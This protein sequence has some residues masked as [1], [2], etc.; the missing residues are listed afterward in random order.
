MTKDDKDDKDNKDDKDHKNE[1]AVLDSINKDKFK[2]Q[3]CES[4][5]K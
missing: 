3:V 5:D 4:Y 1:K 2:S